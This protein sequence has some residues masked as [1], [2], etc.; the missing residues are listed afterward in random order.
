[1][2]TSIDHKSQILTFDQEEEMA[3]N[4]FKFGNSL[5]DAFRKVQDV[6][7]IGEERERI[8]QKV[9]EKLEQEM[10]E[11]IRRKQEMEKMKEDIIKTQQ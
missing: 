10:H 11:V 5:K 6:Q 7:H 8:F 9:K 1:V 2:K 3:Q 4:L